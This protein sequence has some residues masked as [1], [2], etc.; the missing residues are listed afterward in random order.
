MATLAD[1]GRINEAL[2]DEEL[3]RLQASWRVG[4]ADSDGILLA[5][6][7]GESQLDLLDRFDRPQLAEVIR[8][9]RESKSLSAAGRKLFAVSRAKRRSTND[10]DRLRKYLQKFELTWSD[11]VDS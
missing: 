5:E 1:G 10:A 3:Q 8:V 2:V 9:C 6:I 11:I 7:L 4:V